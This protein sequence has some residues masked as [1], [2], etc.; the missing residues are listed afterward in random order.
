LFDRHH[1]AVRAFARRTAPL[2]D[3][4]DLTSEAF[5]RAF[6]LLKSGSGP[7]ENLRGYLRTTVRRLRIDAVLRYERRIHLV[8]DGREL[9]SETHPGAD[10]YA[11]KNWEASA[12]WRAYLSLPVRWQ[13]VLMHTVID[14]LR[15]AAL[16][17]LYGLAPNSVAVLALRA[18]KG[19]RDALAT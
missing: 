7:T 18:R 14:E 11:I 13:T 8:G 15:P 5:M 16:A 17:Q 1:A 9:D 3:A 4:D 12:L 19:L 10:E 2:S 6:R